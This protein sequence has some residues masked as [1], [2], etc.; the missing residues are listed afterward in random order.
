[1]SKVAEVESSSSELRASRVQSDYDDRQWSNAK[2]DGVITPMEFNQYLDRQDSMS[3]S[4]KRATQASSSSS[5]APAQVLPPAPSPEVGGGGGLLGCM[6]SPKASS[7]GDLRAQ[8]KAM[9]RERELLERQL[10]ASQ[11]LCE[12]VK[13]QLLEERAHCRKLEGRPPNGDYVPPP[14]K[15]PHGSSPRGWET[16]GS[17]EAPARQEVALSVLAADEM[18][19]V[20]QRMF[21]SLEVISTDLPEVVERVVSIAMRLLNCERVTIFLT[22]NVARR[23][24]VLSS[25]DDLSAFTIEFGQGLAGYAAENRVIIN[26]ADAYEDARFNPKVDEETGFRTR[27]VLCCPMIEPSG[28]LV[29]VLQAINPLGGGSFDDKE[30]VQLQCMQKSISIALLNARLHQSLRAAKSNSAHLLQARTRRAARHAPRPSSPLG[31]SHAPR[32]STPPTAARCALPAARCPL[33]LPRP[34]PLPRRA[35]HTPAPRARARALPL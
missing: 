19:Y 14:S 20:L 25:V 3:G 4:K 33:Y 28:Q 17:H 23:L 15:S 6:R 27:S 12:T 2:A 30:L 1:M 35:S 34:T 9:A 8:L 11:Q 21:E 22:D 24:R 31:A 7:D 10:L 13:A 29:A 18:S 26:V 16:G 32:P 5:A